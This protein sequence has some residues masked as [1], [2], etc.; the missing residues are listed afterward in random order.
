VKGSKQSLC[1]ECGEFVINPRIARAT[2]KL[3]ALYHD[4]L[5]DIQKEAQ[6]IEKISSPFD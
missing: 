6:R 5:L 1:E 4:L 2:T 3:I